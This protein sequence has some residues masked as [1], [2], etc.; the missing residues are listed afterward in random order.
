MILSNCTKGVNCELDTIV[1][2][3]ETGKSHFRLWHTMNLNFPKMVS[4]DNCYNP[5]KY[6][7]VQD[8]RQLELV[9]K[10]LENIVKSEIQLAKIFKNSTYSNG[11]YKNYYQRINPKEPIKAIINLDTLISILQLQDREPLVFKP[12]KKR[13]VKNGFLFDSQYARIVGFTDIENNIKVIGINNISHE[14]KDFLKRLKYLMEK[15]DLIYVNYIEEK[16]VA[17]EEIEDYYGIY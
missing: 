15:F 1:K 7:F 4:C 8:F 9:S 2:S 13:M 14:N 11:G 17:S 5:K 10:S 16:V 6:F 12:C 3:I